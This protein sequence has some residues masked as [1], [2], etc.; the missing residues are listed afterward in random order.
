M[1]RSWARLGEGVAKAKKK[2][3]RHA[4]TM[5]AGEVNSTVIPCANTEAGWGCGSGSRVC[6]SVCESVYPCA[7]ACVPV[8]VCGS[9]WDSQLTNAAHKF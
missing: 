7:C 6:A 5:E 3:E 9:V 4:T 1:G 8:C 2:L